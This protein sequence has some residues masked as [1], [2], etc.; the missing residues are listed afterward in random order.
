MVEVRK[1]LI[2]NTI[3]RLMLSAEEL[4]VSML[5]DWFFW[6]SIPLSKSICG[7]LKYSG[8]CRTSLLARL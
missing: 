8:G 5:I 4:A 1:G 3:Y 7:G 2:R 6:C